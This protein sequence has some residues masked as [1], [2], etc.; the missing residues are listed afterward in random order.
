M[1]NVQ[2]EWDTQKA[3]A[4]EKKHGITFARAAEAYLDPFAYTKQDRF[5]NGEYRWQTIGVTN[6]GQRLLLIAHV[7]R[8]E[9]QL[10]VVRIISA[11]KATKQEKKRYD[12]NQIH[13]R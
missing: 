11:R 3:I 4:N 12:D 8:Y 9:S 1:I 13:G 6:D 2:F 10:E 7:N 5:E